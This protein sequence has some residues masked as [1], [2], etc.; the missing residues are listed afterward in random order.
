MKM[1]KRTKNIPTKDKIVQ[2]TSPVE[3]PSE[4]PNKLVYNFLKANKLRM[5]IVA[6]EPEGGFVGDGFLLEKKPILKI[7]F[8]RV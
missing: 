8:E 4:N 5:K 6:I 7:I 2:T 1:D 3:L